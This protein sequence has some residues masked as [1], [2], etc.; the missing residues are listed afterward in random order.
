MLKGDVFEYQAFENQIFAL[1]ISMFMNSANGVARGYKNGMNI[2]YSGHEVTIN[3]GACLVQG[4]FLEEDSSTTVDAGI[5]T[6]FCKLVV[7]IDLDKINTTQEFNQGSYVIVKG[8]SAYPN[9]TQEDTV[10]T[11]EGKYQY[12]LARFKISEGAVTEF[13]D[14]RTYI[15]DFLQYEGITALQNSK[16]PKSHASADTTYGLATK[17]AYGHV[18]LFDDTN[19]TQYNDGEGASR[20]AL[21]LLKDI[22]NGKANASH[23]HTKSQITDFPAKNHASAGTDYGLGTNS[24]YGHNK[25][26]N[27]LNSSAYTNGE[28]LSA[29]QGAV[30]KK[31][32][33]DATEY[34][35]GDTITFSHLIVDG[36]IT[37]NNTIYFCVPTFKSLKNISNISSRASN[38]FIPRGVN[39]YL[40]SYGGSQILITDRDYTVTFGKV[41]ENSILVKIVYEDMRSYYDN[42]VNNTPVSISFS[43]LVLSLS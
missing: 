35:S 37:G 41:G 42:Y 24:N 9:L 38:L 40:D 29:Y 21:K 8:S 4:R 2:T 14:K 32:I 26:I 27:N 7:E 36:Y 16:A 19:A 22:I 30:L 43:E 13:Q 1:F 17:N 18:K 11:N 23:T 6:A 20:Y 28:S 33:S 3:S 12:E 39:G 31:M 5:E 25:V 10:G 34:K 15:Q